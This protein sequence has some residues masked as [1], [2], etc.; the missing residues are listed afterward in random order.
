[1]LTPPVQSPAKLKSLFD[2]DQALHELSWVRHE[3]RKI[4]A[5]IQQE[6][7]KLK[8][9]RQSKYQVMI[10]GSESSLAERQS[11]LQQSL[12]TWCNHYLDGHLETEPKKRL[13]LPH[14]RV[15]QRTLP[16]AIECSEGVKPKDV[17]D[18]LDRKCGFREKINEIAA[19]VIGRFTL[20]M[21]VE[22]KPALSMVGLRN[23]FK[24]QRV[25]EKT[26]NTFGLSVRKESEEIF[27]DSAEYQTDANSPG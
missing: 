26:L 11:S 2:V 25:D 1:M 22:F 18:K 10:N 3:Q 5:A 6:I 24:A 4:D 13:D 20:G 9:E 19:K 14:G 8:G 12:T 17:F 16:L 7:D 15:G 21:F 27:F 23:A